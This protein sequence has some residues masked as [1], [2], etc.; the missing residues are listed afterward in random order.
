ML[1]DSRTDTSSLMGVYFV[2]FEQ[3]KQKIRNGLK[4]ICRSNQFYS[5]V[6]TT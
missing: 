3:I 2:H 1:T 6:V 5:M 4:R